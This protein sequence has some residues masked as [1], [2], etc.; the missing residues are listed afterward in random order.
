MTVNVATVTTI[1]IPNKYAVTFDVNG[2]EPSLK[3]ESKKRVPL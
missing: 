1:W 3:F 2:V